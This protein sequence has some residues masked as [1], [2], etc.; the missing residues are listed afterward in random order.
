MVLACVVS[1]VGTSVATVR[2]IPPTAIYWSFVPIVEILAL[3]IVVWRRRG[4]RGL[5]AL[6]DIFFAGHGAWTLLILAAGAVMAVASPGVWWFLITRP[7]IA[8]VLIVAGWSAYVDVCFFTYVCGATRARAIGDA[9]LH[10]LMAWTLIF[11]IF[12]VPEPTPFG[13]IQ[14]IVEAVAE[15]LR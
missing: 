11:W 10:R 3:A 14:E 4:A 1:L 6:I 13:V 9:V 2:L 8:G 12:A 5:P 7:G 15:L